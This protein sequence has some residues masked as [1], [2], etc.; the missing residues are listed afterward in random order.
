MRVNELMTTDVQAVAGDTSIGE[1]VITLADAGLY[2]V[3]V[4]DGKRLIGVLSTR[5]IL[6]AEAECA[7][8]QTRGN[9]SSRTR[10]CGKS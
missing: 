7:E 4:L 1:A 10:R 8:T 3:P 2:G 9:G 6:D 5:D